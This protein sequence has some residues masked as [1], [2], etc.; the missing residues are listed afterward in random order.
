MSA[1]S[2]GAPSSEREELL[3]SRWK[4]PELQNPSA[5]GLATILVV[6]LLPRIA[7]VELPG[8]YFDECCSWKISQFPWNEMLD[9][10]A[11]DAH[12]PVFYVLLK[13]VGQWIGDSPIVIRGVSIALGMLTIVAAFALVRQG[14]SEPSAFDDGARHPH[15]SDRDFAALL[16]A[17]LVASS[18]LQIELSLQGRPYTLGTLVA[19]LAAIFL[20]Q[21]T[22]LEGRWFHWAGFA[23]AAGLLSFTHYYGLFT[24]ASLLLYAGLVFLAEC[25]R[26]GWNSRAKEI[27]LGLGLSVWGLFFVWSLWLPV[28]QFQRNRTTAQL[29]MPPLN[30][31]EF[32][33]ALWM[34]MAGGKATPAVS[35]IAWLAV[36]AW[37]IAVLALFFF[38]N[39][40]GRLAAVCAGGPLLAAIAYGSLERNILG[41]KYLAFTQ[42]FLLVGGALLVSRIR[43]RPGRFVLAAGL[44]LWNGFWCWQFVETREL[45]AEQPG[46]CGA[47]EFLE[48]RRRPNEPVIVGSPFVYLVVQKYATHPEGI[49]V[50]YDGDHR[51]DILG[52]T[53]R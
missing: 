26:N 28:F 49:Y 33:S 48:Q 9:A 10:V 22:G 47:V 14:L 20:A 52:S 37:A 25:L 7:R 31:H 40:V 23:I 32:S 44:I 42:V 11:R 21:A 53:L 13:A 36:A 1:A 41:V 50:N 17:M 51:Q 30:W 15:S 39:R 6:G 34:A 8:M 46:I 3:F 38:G 5:L 4:L 27:C 2:T 12:P 19:L 45:Q 43:W 24:V 35:S 29:W 16:A 18:A